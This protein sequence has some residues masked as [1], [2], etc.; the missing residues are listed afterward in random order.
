MIHFIKLRIS[1]AVWIIEQ[2]EMSRQ[3]VIEKADIH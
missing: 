1:T 2:Y 3:L